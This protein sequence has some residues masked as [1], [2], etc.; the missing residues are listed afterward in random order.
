MAPALQASKAVP[1]WVDSIRASSRTIVRE[2]GFMDTTL[3]ATGYPPSAVHALIEI[4]SR[5]ALSAH[6]LAQLLR[7]EKSSISRM[8]AKL[9]HAGELKETASAQDGRAKV[10]ALTAKGRRTLKAID[11]FAAR[12]VRTALAALSRDQQHTVVRGLATYA[13]ALAHHAPPDTASSPG[14]VLIT[15]GYRTGVIGR[16]T[17]MHA[18]FY[19][20]LGLGEFFERQVA[21]GMSGF[22]AQLAHRGNGLWV[23]LQAGR[24]V[25]SVA[26]DAQDLGQGNAHLRWFIVDDGVRGLGV[27]K[28]LLAAAI[29]FCERQRFQ[30]IHLWTFQGL[31]AARHLYES[32]G[33]A[34]AEQRLGRQWG[35]EV[36]EQR[37]VRLVA[38]R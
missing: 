5:K 35:K 18:T 37:F 11:A 6:D 33:F 15:Q 28:R 27:G 1:G 2:L 19:A 32:A 9:V 17:E 3:A 4:G 34:L 31:D 14:P 26:I 12:E 16:V 8:V 22:A 21:T 25:G 7:L 29:E 36:M 20:H 38:K 10:L 23:A 24:I 30:A 13:S